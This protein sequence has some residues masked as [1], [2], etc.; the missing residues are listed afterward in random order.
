M[1]QTVFAEAINQA[2]IE[3]MR[4]EENVFI[5]GEEIR[6]AV[7][8]ATANLLS[9]FGEERVLDTPPFRKWFFWGCYRRFVSW[10]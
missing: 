10:I 3:E 9:E 8:G 2:H 6:R 5:M 4:R 7:Y 1:T